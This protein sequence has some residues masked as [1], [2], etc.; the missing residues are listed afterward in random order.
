MSPHKKRRNAGALLACVAA[1]S[2]VDVAPL[3]AQ[4]APMAGTPIAA[5]ATANPADI[6]AARARL[7][8]LRADMARDRRTLARDLAGGTPWMAAIAALRDPGAPA[9]TGP[10]SV[11]PPIVAALPPIDGDPMRIDGLPRRLAGLFDL[12]AAAEAGPA[13]YDAVH[14]RARLLPPAPPSTL[15]LGEIL[16]WIEATPGQPHAIGRYQIIPDTLRYLMRA[17]RLDRS[18]VFSPALQDRLATRLVLDAGLRDYLSGLIPPRAFMDRL[19]Y[20]W[21]GLPLA[22]GRSAYEGIAGNKATMTRA[23][24][25]A[26]FLAILPPPPLLL[27]LP[28]APASGPVAGTGQP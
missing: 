14:L 23:R 28:P 10:G 9:A 22:D 8:G 2:L 18:A 26:A 17:E 21:A 1:W 3:R 20:V 15:T 5:P 12:I 7:A 16:D 27:G 13:Q 4:T 24:Y 19:A 6:A 11:S 25:E